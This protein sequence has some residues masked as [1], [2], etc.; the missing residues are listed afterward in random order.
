MEP[1]ASS[2]AL[3]GE[4]RCTV[5]IHPNRREEVSYSLQGYELRSANVEKRRPGNGRGGA[6]CTR[7]RRSPRGSG[8]NTEE[9]R[10]DSSSSSGSARRARG[11]L[12][13]VLWRPSAT[14]RF[15]SIAAGRLAGALAQVI[16]ESRAS[17]PPFLVS[18]IR[19][20]GAS[21]KRAELPWMRRSPASPPMSKRCAGGFAIPSTGQQGSA[22]RKSRLAFERRASASGGELNSVRQRSILLLQATERPTP[23]STSKRSST[24]PSPAPRARTHGRVVR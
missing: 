11:V 5:Q 1:C 3:I 21:S 12:R 9:R 15:A 13:D 19:S 2:T 23:S 8:G 18:S 20:C 22:P 4:T 7:W 6:T 17:A 24:W 14:S 16:P 10:A